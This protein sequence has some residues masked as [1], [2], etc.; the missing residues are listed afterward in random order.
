[1][2]N[3]NVNSCFYMARAVVPGMQARQWGRLIHISGRD[4]GTG[5]TCRAHNVTC[6]AGM[7]ALCQAIGL[8]FGPDGITASTVCPGMIDTVRDPKNYPDYV[9]LSE[10]RRRRLPVRRLGASEDIAAAC[11]YLASEA[12]GFV[13]GQAIHVNGGEFMF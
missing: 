10:R 4:G 2:I 5:L 7:F 9:N 13:A 1:M 12:G 8:E 3:T 6:K 11:L